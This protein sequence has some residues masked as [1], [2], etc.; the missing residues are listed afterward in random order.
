M[1]RRLLGLWI[2]AALGLGAISAGARAGDVDD[3]DR[4][5][6]DGQGPRATKVERRPTPEAAAVSSTSTTLAALPAPRAPR[7]APAQPTTTVVPPLVAGAATVDQPGTYIV[8]R[9]GSGL[10]RVLDACSVD[11]ARMWITPD[12]LVMTDTAH[13]PPS[14]LWLDGRTGAYPL[15]QLTDR[16]GQPIPLRG[17]GNPS[18]DGELAAF[19]YIGLSEYGVA[20]VDLADQT[21]EVVYR[22]DNP[23]P[24]WSPT[25]E[26]L[27]VGPTSTALIDR[28]GAVLRDWAPSPISM[29]GPFIQWSP[30]GR[31]LVALSASDMN[32]WVV[33]D[34]RTN[35][36]ISVPQ[37]GQG[38]N[39]IAWVGPGRLVLADPGIDHQVPS[40]L[41][42][43]DLGS[44]D[45]RKIVDAAWLPAVPV[46][47]QVIAFEDRT[48]YRRIG[49][50]TADGG[51]RAE[52]VTAPEGLWLAPTS[53]SPDGTWLLFNACQRTLRSG[54][55]PTT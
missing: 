12:Q 55:L 46:D 51:R 13:S 45:V 38:W 15:P 35:E 47:G 16:L 31:R 21:A 1:R 18:P 34:V 49:V 7:P 6:A 9:D 43:W 4:V 3:R 50:V 26:I 28:H 54:G 8:R 25:G 11:G 23:M 39:E 5:R 33:M 20:I 48:D 32:R 22:G 44:S 10:R 30:D 29:A 19:S 42:V 17:I 40:S 27:L 53:W 36:T 52:L 41:H 2:A 24:A 14:R 37:V